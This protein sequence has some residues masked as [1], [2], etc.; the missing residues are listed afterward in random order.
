MESTTSQSISLDL[1]ERLNQ[2]YIDS[3]WE[4]Q[5]GTPG[6]SIEVWKEAT[7]DKS[8]L[9]NE[10]VNKVFLLQERP[11]IENPEEFLKKCH[12][13]FGRVPW[14]II[15]TT[16]GSETIKVAASKF[17]MTYFAGEPGML[18]QN[19]PG[20]FPE[21]PETLSIKKVSTPSEMT[22]FFKVLRASFKIPMFALK[23]SYPKVPDDPVSLF[24]GYEANAP[25]GCSGLVCLNGIGGIFS[26][27]TDPKARKRGYGEALTWA[28]VKESRER[29]CDANFLQASEMGASI[30]EKMGFRK[31]ISYPQWT[32]KASL[33]NRLRGLI[34]WIRLSRGNQ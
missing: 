31:V 27:G 10:L 16:S 20:A 34:Y 29:G 32:K 15:T 19:V 25:V 30:Y 24:V 33:I 12:S 9:P 21:P 17:G 26:V 7:L 1:L 4:L 2:S 28:A 13:F 5:K 23:V 14:R 22:D 18:L 3:D 6:A 8:E 11:V